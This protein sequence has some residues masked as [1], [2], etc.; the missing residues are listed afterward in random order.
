MDE[1][2]KMIIEYDMKPGW[3]EACHRYVVHE[4]GPTLDEYG[5]QF[6]NA[7]YTA[8]GKGPQIMGSGLF[9]S[10]ESVRNLLLSDEWR[11]TLEGLSAYATHISVRFIVPAETFQ[12]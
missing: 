3:E 7:W 4:M 12:V 9:D 5:F 2:I 11:Q 6:L 8:W 10:P 1:P